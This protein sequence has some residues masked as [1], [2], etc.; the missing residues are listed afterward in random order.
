MITFTEFYKRAINGETFRFKIEPQGTTIYAI[1]LSTSFGL[2]M[3]ADEEANLDSPLY[4]IPND[5]DGYRKLENALRM[6]ASYH[7]EKYTG[8]I[9]LVI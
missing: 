9:E 2:I 4:R 7:G 5:F 6:L 3:G 1:E 8:N